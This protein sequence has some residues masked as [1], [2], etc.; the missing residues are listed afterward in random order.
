MIK[1]SV[2]SLSNQFGLRS[3]LGHPVDMQV[4]WECKKSGNMTSEYKLKK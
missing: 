1:F 2:F 3:F 4:L